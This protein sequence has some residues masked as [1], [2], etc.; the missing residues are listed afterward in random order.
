ME[1]DQ[2]YPL[3]SSWSFTRQSRGQS[4]FFSS[5]IGLPP[6]PMVGERLVIDHRHRPTLVWSG[7]GRYRPINGTFSCTGF[8]TVNIASLERL[9][10]ASADFY[11][12]H[13]I[14]ACSNSRQCEQHHAELMAKVLALMHKQFTEKFKSGKQCVLNCSVNNHVNWSS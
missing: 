12:S 9:I 11:I 8:P 10:Q 13:W 3:S 4:D 7:T 6:R 1:N 14:S 5:Q 2:L